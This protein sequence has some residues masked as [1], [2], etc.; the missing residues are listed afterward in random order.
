MEYI[1][2]TTE[3]Q[4]HNTCVTLGKFDGL[5]RGHQL[6]LEELAKWEALGYTSVMFTFDYHPENLFSEREIDLIYTE[7]E[8]RILLEENGPKVLI[9][10]PFTKESA[11]IEPEEFIRKILVEQLDAKVIVVGSDYRFG[12]KRRGDVT[13]LKQFADQFGIEL[14]ICDKLKYENEVISSTRIREELRIGHIRQVNDM[15]GHPFTIMGEVVHG[16]Q[17][18][19][20]LQAPTVNLLPASHK[21]LPP[22]GVYAS[23]VIHQGKEYYAVTNIGCK[24][25]VESNGRVGVESHILDFNQD[26]YGHF[27]QVELYEYERGEVHFQSLEELKS[28]L[29][30]DIQ[31]AKQVFT[32]S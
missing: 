32:L 1:F 12:R 25:T 8:K 16:N 23:K 18:G 19:R 11:S 26:I 4:Y 15:L 22:R 27:I 21:L 29:K 9:S 31:F 6:L 2:E 5:H 13:M 28:Q 24:P 20:T 30:T 3:F 10:Y 14:I 17:I 7:E